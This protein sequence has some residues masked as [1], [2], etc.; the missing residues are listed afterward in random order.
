MNEEKSMVEYKE[1]KGILGWLKS[2]F[3]KIKEKFRTTRNEQREN[4]EN[5]EE[6]ELFE[7][8]LDKV[9]GGIP[10]EAVNMEE[11]KVDLGLTEPKSWNL[12]EEEQEIVEDGYEEIRA[13][14]NQQEQ[15]EQ[16]LYEED[17]DQ[18]TAGHPIVDDEYSR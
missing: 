5:R 7:E 12:T 3:E 15:E 17:L 10:F 11:L 2:R 16:E 8:D 14:Y 9:P 4:K 1:S 18:I 13:S 6:Q